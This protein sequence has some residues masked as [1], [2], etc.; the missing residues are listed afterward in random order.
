MKKAGIT[1]AA[2]LMAFS[3]SMGVMAQE[4]KN[5]FPDC[6]VD[7]DISSAK[8]DLK[9]FLMPYAFGAVDD[10]HNTYAMTFLYVGMPAEQAEE[11]LYSSDLNEEEIKQLEAAQFLA[12]VVL[13]TSETLDSAADVFEVYTEGEFV[14]DADRAEKI[15]SAES[16][17]F[18]AVP[19]KS[20]DYL[21]KAGEPY[22]DEYKKLEKTLLE[23]EKGAKVYA[24][25]DPVKEHAN[26]KLSFTTTDLDGNTV[27]SEEL[28]SANEIT[29]LN[30]WGTWCPNCMA[31]MEELAK[32]HKEMQEKGCG[33]VGL[34]WESSEEDYKNAPKVLEEFGTSYPNVRFPEKELSWVE[35]FPTSIFV[36]KEGNILSMPIVGLQLKK[37]SS[38]LDS[39]LAGRTE[40]ETEAGAEAGSAEEAVLGKKLGSESMAVYIVTV[41]DEDGPVED[42]AVQLCTDTSCTFK[43]TGADGVAAFESVAGGNCEVHV[44]EA[45]EGYKEDEEIYHPDESGKVTIT[46]Q[47][48]D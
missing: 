25:E 2:A 44:M 3:M 1:L 48:E 23:L 47:K 4:S 8:E 22:A 27:T 46:L 26:A 39:L 45:P 34:E 19:L 18:Y 36:D 6:G 11:W 29:M 37:Y 15:G 14:L 12:P 16:M 28:F 24:P 7:I 10:A 33:I 42:A 20:E 21:S 9:G 43:S 13:G 31:E 35:G 30:C 5:S 17:T 32:L 38:V 40:T 41:V